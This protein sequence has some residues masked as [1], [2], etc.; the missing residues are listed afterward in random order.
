MTTWI[1]ALA[2]SLCL[3][4]AE[5]AP[6]GVRRLS[7]GHDH[8]EASSGLIVPE[9]GGIFATTGNSHS[10]T[11]QQV[12]GAYAAATMTVVMLP[13]TDPTEATLHSLEVEAEHGFEATCTEV[14]PG[15]TIVPVEDACF[16]L[17]LEGTD[18]VFTIDTTGLTGLA[19]YAEH[20][21][22]EFER[23][24]HYLMD[25]SGADVEAVATFTGEDHAAHDE[26]AP[27]P[28]AAAEGVPVGAI[29]GIIAG[30][31]VLI[32]IG[33]GAAFYM[34]KKGKT[35]TSPKQSTAV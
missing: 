1:L 3:A 9:F 23:D 24:A 7:D 14:E 19:I 21:L 18:S 28:P 26:A 34:H 35:N 8:G 12:D 2:A 13:T 4:S 5:A 32:V 16:E 20:D 11:L 10:F 22:A 15:E 33:S 25:S 29:I 31:V 6:Y 30:V 27:P 17:H